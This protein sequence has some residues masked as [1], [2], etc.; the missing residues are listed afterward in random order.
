MMIARFRNRQFVNRPSVV[1]F[2]FVVVPAVCWIV[3]LLDCFAFS[4]YLFACV[5]FVV[6]LNIGAGGLVGLR[7]RKKTAMLVWTP[8]GRTRTRARGC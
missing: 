2:L 4:M 6:L 3:G 1:R 5:V 7:E 8:G